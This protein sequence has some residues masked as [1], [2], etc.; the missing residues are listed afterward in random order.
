MAKS[1]CL[2]YPE[3]NGKPSKLYKD[4]L[5][6]RKLSRPLANLIYSTYIASN[7]ADA[8]D[9]VKDAKGNPKYKR[10]AQG[11]NNVSD[12]MEFLDVYKMLNEYSSLSSEEQSWGFVDSNGQRVD[13]TDGKEALEKADKFNDA[14]TGLVATVR[15]HGNIFNI[16][17]FEK[18]AATHNHG[19]AI[20]DRLKVW[21]VEKQ[22]FAAVGIDL[23]GMPQEVK[24]VINP[25]TADLVTYLKN[26]QMLG[27]QNLYKTDALLLFNM[28]A[29][30]QEVRRLIQ[31]FGSIDA[32]AEA[33]GNINHGIGNYTQG[34]KT[35][36]ARA[37]RKCKEYRGIDLDALK[38][39]VEQTSKDIIENS[40]EQPIE[41][42]L[43]KL[44]KK[45]KINLNEIHRI[46]KDINTLSEAATDAAYTLKR[47]IRQLEKQIGNNA[48]G[49]RLERILNQLMS[50]LANKK[51]YSGIL[52]FLKEAQSNVA[53]IESMLSNIQQNGTELEKAFAA[54]R[55]IQDIRQ[56]RMQYY[57]LVSA[58]SNERLVID[59]AIGQ[60]DISN[61][62][63]TAMS[64]KKVFDK[65]FR[66]K[67][68]DPRGLIDTLERRTMISILTEII[69]PTDPSG[70][71]ISNLV[72]MAAADSSIIDYLYSIGRA[73]NPIIAAMGS[74]IRNAQ[75]SRDGILNDISLRIRRATDRLYKSGKDSSYIYE[76]SGHIISDIDW[77][78]YKAARK[79]H[80]KS[81]Y[82]Q[83]L[84][85]FDLKEAI[86][87]WEDVNTEDRVVDSKNG[88]TERVPNSTYRQDNG[89]VWDSQ[90][91]IMVFT[92]KSDLTK[93]Q[94]DYYNTMMQLK[95]E[96]G[97]LLPAYAQH[98]YLPPQ[99]R[100]NTFDALGQAKNVAD[101]AKALK[102]KMQ[103]FTKIRE[104]D[105]NYNMNGII[106]GD[107]YVVTNGAFDNTEL[108]QI[109]IF[110]VNQVEQRELLKNFSTGLQ[111]L[112]GTAVNYDAMNNVAQVVEFIGD[113]TKG[114]SPRSKE[115]KA[116]VIENKVIRVFKPLLKWGKNT[117]TDGLI[118]G[119]ISQHIYGQKLDPEQI[120]YKHAKLVSN[121][122]GYTSFKGLA[123]NVKGALSNYLVGEFQMLIEAGAGEFYGLSDYAW[124]HKKLFGGSGVGGEIAE[125]LTNNMSHKATLFRELFD[126]LQENFSDK[127]HTKYYKSMF[128]QLISHDCS[129]LGY[130]A[131][132]YLI[133][134]VNMYAI[135]HKQKVKLNGKT[136]SLYD[137]FETTKVEDGNSELK[138]KDGVTQLDGSKVTDEYLNEI[139]GKIKY[140]NQTTHGSM[141]EEDKGLIHQ[142]LWGRAIMNFRQWMVEHYS[143]RFRTRHFD[144]SLG[145]DREGYWI[146]F[147]HY[148]FNE[149]TKDT[150]KEGKKLSAIGM[151]VKDYITFMFRA[152]SQ[153]HNLDEMQRHN[154]KRVHTEMMMYFALLGLSF[155]LGEPDKHKKEFWRRWWIYQVK[156]M[157]LDTEASMPNPHMIS[158]GLTIL[159]SPIAGVNTLNSLLYSWYGITNGDI[160]TK[161]K[162]GPHKGENKYWRN[163]RKYNMPF[164]KD[165]EQMQRMSED[166]SIFQVFKDTPSN[167]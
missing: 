123:T 64:I 115:Q 156:R 157:I 4:L 112:A 134:Y 20:K 88:R 18:N 26:M 21:D 50:E 60:E 62:R 17:V 29:N 124:A 12:V 106:D 163:F 52:N 77:G 86:E 143:R 38:A 10:N 28:D 93:A 100:R 97:S 30:S 11:E 103:D 105:D 133:H 96:I 47:Q 24:A 33:M 126:P 132:E 101:V 148:L 81:L 25:T 110:Y 149:D 161:I 139:K 23:E 70:Q 121:L 144:A 151:F 19:T 140:A 102:N 136:I 84:R 116:D 41:E 129:F 55:T 78:L 75:G 7:A 53:Q 147:Y 45:Y 162:S 109:P 164:F 27:I 138:L 74:I 36:L 117:N 131:G 3:I 34:Q 89:M 127:S 22:A 158:S 48:E 154:V 159:Q 85:G 2:W 15:K 1:S 120:G 16:D 31:S 104:D 6:K 130:A 35:L 118:D 79:A 44:N 46:G 8:M 54:A 66:E 56:L 42:T 76:D 128:R 153:W 99:L 5:E 67:P 39:Q 125:L 32:A 72:D 9:K 91:N 68:N 14:H 167:N 51:Y 108:R 166:E 145:M 49:K 113:Y 165:W 82:K 73:S 80:I 87:D 122:I 155:A 69:G 63:Q 114:Q 152:Q 137:A 95:G 13:F 58:L 43:K 83:G 142:K 71:I 40:P 150:W 57:P 98:Q 94:Q 90:N 160:N 59:E 135:L 119:Y 61:I 107:E 146:S 141:N 65:Y 37:V 111:A 92:P